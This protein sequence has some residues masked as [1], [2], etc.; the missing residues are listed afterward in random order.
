MGVAGAASFL[1]QKP[2]PLSLNRGGIS[3]LSRL[4][5]PATPSTP[6]HEVGVLGV[7]AAP[8]YLSA[9]FPIV[10]IHSL[11]HPCSPLSGLTFIHEATCPV[12]G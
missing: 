8:T 4:K 2:Q 3:S 12:L 5:C 1:K 7:R 10:C 9:L 11:S 6:Y